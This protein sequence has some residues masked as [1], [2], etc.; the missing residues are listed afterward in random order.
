MNYCSTLITALLLLLLCWT[1]G[2]EACPEV[3]SGQNIQLF[4]FAHILTAEWAF[5][6]RPKMFSFSSLFSE[7]VKSQK[8]TLWGSTFIV[9]QRTGI[10][11]CKRSR[12]EKVT[13][14]PLRCV[15]TKEWQHGC[16]YTSNFLHMYWDTDKSNT[17]LYG[18][19]LHVASCSHFVEYNDLSKA[20]K[21][22]LAVSL[23]SL[24]WT[25]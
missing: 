24:S 1:C 21:S 8:V 3:I 16:M 9:A 22:L 14:L 13:A 12:V 17:C 5:F 4:I 7:A 2:T 25:E 20:L 23:F 19:F 15:F 10:F 18:S 11:P 6:L